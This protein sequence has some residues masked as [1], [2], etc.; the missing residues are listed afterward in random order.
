MALCGNSLSCCAPD[1]KVLLDLKHTYFFE[2]KFLL[3]WSGFKG[4]RF[5]LK[6]GRIVEIT[7]YKLLYIN[8]EQF[9]TTR[10]FCEVKYILQN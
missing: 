3:Y 5:H 10:N 8:Y 9:I 7:F 1:E 4:F 6:Y 2:K